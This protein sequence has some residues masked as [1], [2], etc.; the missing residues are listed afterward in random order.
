MFVKMP[1]FL[2]GWDFE[3]HT[4]VPEPLDYSKEDV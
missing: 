4:F 3:S 1:Q 2:L